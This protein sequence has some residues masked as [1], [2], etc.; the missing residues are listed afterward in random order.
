MRLVG[1]VHDRPAQVRP[2]RVRLAQVPQA[3]DEASA[4]EALGLR[5]RLIVGSTRNMKVTYPGDIALAE[6]LLEGQEQ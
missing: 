5:P 2:E 1:E 3:T 6:R 4:V